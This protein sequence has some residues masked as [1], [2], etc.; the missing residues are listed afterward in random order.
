MQ[1]SKYLYDSWKQ[2]NTFIYQVIWKWN[3]LQNYTDTPVY[4]SIPWRCLENIK[5]RARGNR[6]FV[7]SS[8]YD[9]L[10]YLLGNLLAGAYNESYLSSTRIRDCPRNT[11]LRSKSRNIH[12]TEP[13][14]ST[15]RFDTRPW[16]NHR[17]WPKGFKGVGRN[18]SAAWI[19]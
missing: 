15:I 9:E 16:S 12:S 5:P 4:S 14:C 6:D 11:F 2:T 17:V 19:F 13:T 3:S 7:P 10:K 8:L 18:E 1:S